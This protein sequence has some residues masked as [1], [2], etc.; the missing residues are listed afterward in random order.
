MLDARRDA[1]AGSVVRSW[2]LSK[3]ISAERPTYPPLLLDTRKCWNAEAPKA[4]CALGCSRDS[5]A[6]VYASR[7]ACPHFDS[8]YIRAV[9]MAQA[10]EP[11]IMARIGVNEQTVRLCHR[12]SKVQ[13]RSH[14]GLSDHYLPCGPAER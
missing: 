6:R 8:Y 13:R 12:R 2:Y 9:R 14:D 11:I 3:R 4:P 10:N 1:D 7:V 5:N